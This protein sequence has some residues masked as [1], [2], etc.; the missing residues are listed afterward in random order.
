MLVPLSL[1]LYSHIILQWLHSV[2]NIFVRKPFVYEEVC[3]LK[4]E[5]YSL[6]RQNSLRYNKMISIIFGC[7]FILDI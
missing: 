3:I 7:Y 4:I 6:K 5:K 2:E 1:R